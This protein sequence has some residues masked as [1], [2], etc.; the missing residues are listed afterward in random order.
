VVRVELAKGEVTVRLL[1]FIFVLLG[2]GVD[3]GNEFI[4][5]AVPFALQLLFLMAFLVAGPTLPVLEIAF[6]TWN[7]LTAD[8]V[9]GPKYPFGVADRY[10]FATRYLCNFITELS[11][12]ES[13]RP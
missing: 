11:V 2:T 13:P 7:F 5:L 9:P 10:P 3:A 12:T 6:A 4:T 8:N 1:G